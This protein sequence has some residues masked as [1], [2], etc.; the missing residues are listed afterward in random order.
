[1]A[2]SLLR[3]VTKALVV[4]AALTATGTIARNQT[5]TTTAKS[6][7]TWRFAVSGDSRNCG[8]VV[9]PAIAADVKKQGAIFYWHLGDFRWI[10][11]IDEDMKCGPKHLDGPSGYIKYGLTAW[12]DFQEN[13]IAGFGSVPVFLGI[14]NHE[15]IIHTDRQDFLHEF[16]NWLDSPVLRAQRLKDDPEDHNPHSN[17]HWIDRGIDF[18]NLDNATRKDFSDAQMKWFQGVLSR[19]LTDASVKTLVVGMHKALPDSISFS[20]SMSESQPGI[21]TG[22]RVYSS[23]LDAQNKAGKHVYVLA[24]HSHFYADNIYDTDHWRTN[25]GVLPGWIVGTAG[26]HRYCLPNGVQEGPHARRNV[27]GYLLATAH[28]GGASDGVVEFTFVEVHPDQVPEE[29]QKRFDNGFVAWCFSEN[30]DEA[31]N[32]DVKPQCGKSAAADEEP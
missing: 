4:I 21:D 7:T 14:G 32:P 19:D 25:G 20:H 13:Q 16:A 27:S 28:S 29:V 5:A 8:D 22:R 6:E 11:D 31:C 26:A 2:R 24:S 9:M 12:N 23:L 18:I 30:R 10:L 15:M 3:D 17:Y 1:M